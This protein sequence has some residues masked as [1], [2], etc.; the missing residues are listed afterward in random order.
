[1]C[2]IRIVDSL[3]FIFSTLNVIHYHSFWNTSNPSQMLNMSEVPEFTEDLF[4][5]RTL[6]MSDRLLLHEVEGVL[7]QGWLD[8]AD[9][10]SEHI[11]PLLLLQ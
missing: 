11:L 6:Q 7:H 1:M 4:G 5:L 9:I 3:I 10:F 8:R 2:S